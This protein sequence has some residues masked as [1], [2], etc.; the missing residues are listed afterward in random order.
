MEG[1]KV[2]LSAAERGRYARHLILPDMGIK[3]Q[4]RLK[5][6]SVC[7]VGAGGL[8]SPALLYLAAAGVGRIGIIDDDIVDLTNLQRQVIH[9][10]A[11]VGRA[12]A[13][14]AAERLKGINPEVE[15]V[16]HNCRLGAD[17]ALDILGEYDV[18]VDGVDNIPTRYIISDAC[19]MLG[20][21][22]VYGSIFRFEGQV[23]L[24]N[25]EGGPNY[26]DL[27]PDP[28]PPE[29]VPSCE[30][31]GVLGV[32]PAVV[33]SIQATEALKLVLGIGE[34]L[35]G[36]L[37]IYDAKYMDFRTLKVGSIPDREPVTELTTL[38]A[39][40]STQDG[41]E[42]EDG[43]SGMTTSTRLT[44]RAGASEAFCG[45]QGER[46][47][48]DGVSGTTTPTAEMESVN[49]PFDGALASVRPDRYVELRKNGW[50]PFLLDVRNA[51]EAEIVSL[52]QTE[53]RIDILQLMSR[54]SELPQERDI[55]V[56]CRS[57]A[58]S[59]GAAKAIKKSGFPRAVLNLSGGIHAW[60]RQVDNSVPRY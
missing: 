37:L 27:F 22:W 45:P 59:A 31:A 11:A 58:R 24:F 20:K 14:S 54:L 46:E 33:G 28:P 44:S 26:R 57:G 34:N 40:C 53:A 36:K 17:N 51:M 29:A 42:S 9:S 43:A 49:D 48:E 47:S 25:H 55:V 8:G 2:D 6:A 38:E 5:E 23:S 35:S 41:R 30:E 4:L 18:V 56:Y 32:L 3:G 19:E 15:V 21:P 39:Y 52:P 10:T 1:A 7:V 12:K 50:N 60:S 13:E 16:V